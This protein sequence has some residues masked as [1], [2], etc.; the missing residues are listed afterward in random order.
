MKRKWKGT[1]LQLRDIWPPKHCIWHPFRNSNYH[2]TWHIWWFASA[3]FASVCLASGSA[4]TGGGLLSLNGFCTQVPNPQV[5]SNH[6]SLASPRT[7]KFGRSFIFIIFIYLIFACF[8]HSKLVKITSQTHLSP[9]S[10]A[11]AFAA[12]A[13]S[14]AAAFVEVWP[15]A[16]AV[17]FLAELLPVPGTV[18]K[19]GHG[20]SAKDT[21]GLQQLSSFPSFPYFPV[22]FIVSSRCFSSF[23]FSLWLLCHAWPSRSSIKD[24]RSTRPWRNKHVEN[25]RK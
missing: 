1:S 24:S 2:L 8:F 6:N 12:F 5:A 3:F 17:G 9:V 16:Q 7:R 13:A 15:P 19:H 4:A 14:A 21:A 20:K 18:A 10:F 23:C 22:P 11:A 25:S